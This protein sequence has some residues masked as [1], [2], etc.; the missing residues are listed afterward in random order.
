[1]EKLWGVIVVT[2]FVGIFGFTY[3]AATKIEQWQQAIDLLPEK[4]RCLQKYGDAMWPPAE[5]WK[6][7][8]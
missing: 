2:V 5:C 7:F 6:Y 1:M 3:Y 8:N 4:E